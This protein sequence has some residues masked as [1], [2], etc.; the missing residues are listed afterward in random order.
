MAASLNAVTPG[1]ADAAFY[2]P[3]AS[4]QGVLPSRQKR[5]RAASRAALGKSDP[6]DQRGALGFGV[7][8]EP[9]APLPDVP[10]VRVPPPEIPEPGSPAPLPVPVVPAAPAPD[11]PPGL[12][13]LIWP[14]SV[15][16]VPAPDGKPAP[17]PPA[18][19]AAPP[20]A[21][22]PWAKALAE[23]ARTKATPIA[24]TLPL[25]IIV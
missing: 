19:P 14:A 8:P 13:G 10:G 20:P 3:L 21:P 15:P 11:V 12:P 9:V 2:V 7:L 23:T 22:P 1:N 24:R 6:T 25:L 16:L 18:P 5:C 17:A 4:E